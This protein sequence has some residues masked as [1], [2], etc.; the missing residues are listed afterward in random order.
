MI[1]SKSADSDLKIGNEK[2]EVLFKIKKIKN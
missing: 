1:K 2:F